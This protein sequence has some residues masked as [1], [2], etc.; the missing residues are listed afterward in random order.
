MAYQISDSPIEREMDVLMATGE[1]VS[2]SL[3]SIALNEIGIE[4]V[5]IPVPN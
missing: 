4:A 3:L 2:I 1:Q 5:S